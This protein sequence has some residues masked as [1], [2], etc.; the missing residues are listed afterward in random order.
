MHR[1][2]IRSRFRHVTATTLTPPTLRT[3]QQGP[4]HHHCAPFRIMAEPSKKVAKPTWYDPASSSSAAGE[5]VLKVSNSL[6]KEKVEFRPMQGRNVKWYNCGPTVYDAAHL[7]HARN[8]VSQDIIRRILVD[9]FGYDVHFVMNITDIDDKIIIRARHNYLIDQLNAES[10]SLSKSL[11]TQSSEAWSKYFT[12]KV[13]ARFSPN[14]RPKTESAADVDAAWLHVLEKEKSD[15]KWWSEAKAADEKFTMHIA[16]LRKAKLGIDA[17]QKALE[18]NDTTQVQAT[19]L[20]ES[21]KDVLAPYLD[22]KFGPTLTDPSI[23]RTLAAYWEDEFYKDMSRLR[24]QPAD[25]VTRVTEYVPEIVTFVERIVKNGYAYAT[26][27]GSVYFDTRKFDGGKGGAVAEV[28]KGDEDKWNHFYAKLAPGKKGNKEAL[29]EGEGALTSGAE[30]RFPSDF[31]LW[32]ASKPGEP[33]WPSPWGPGRPGWHIECSVMA[34]EI[35][36]EAMDIHSGGIDLTF[37]H[38]DNEMAQ[39]EAYHDCKQWVNYFLHTGH[40]HIEGLKMSKSLKNFITID[41]ALAMHSARQLRLAF[42]GQLWSSPMD[43][44]ESTMQEVKARETAIDNFFNLA[45]ALI[46]E[47]RTKKATFDGHHHYDQTE[48]E[49]VAFFTQTQH[50]FRSALCDSFNTPWALD[51][52]LELISRTNI[53]V[54]RGRASV[55][56]SVVEMIAKWVT[57]MLRMFGLG[58]GAV[59]PGSIGWG[60]AARE[61]ES[62]VDWDAILLP[63]LQALSTF[64][65][66]IRKL[67]IAQAAPKDILALCDRLRD[68]DLAPLGVAL[69]DQEDGRALVKLVNPDVLLRARDEKAAAL[70]AKAAKKAAAVEAEKAKKRSKMEKGKVAPTEM[71]KA[72]N[73]PEGTYSEWNADGVPTKD[74]EGKELSGAKTKKVAKEWEIQRKLHADYTEWIGAGCP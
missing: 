66:D 60:D 55:N 41:D 4:L 44:K 64:R 22:A 65:D 26:D 12:S 42:L 71:F 61:G 1:N 46:L 73:V 50:D 53:Y 43:F 20:I 36:G 47:S 14:D 33:A 18:A 39:A 5:P 35:L 10:S 29:E 45:R 70:A 56:V 24:I 63:Y 27:D 59:A 51:R 7:G 32:K 72:P 9:Y 25:T 57:K 49:L 30:K 11:I 38:H 34:S 68:I 69:D 19:Q 13:L 23:S 62:A 17:A 48:K 40:L 15:E 74:G 28:K 16:S 3:L 54:Q 2:V 58:E 52:L 21:A 37:P 31:A 8:Y 6:T 67:A